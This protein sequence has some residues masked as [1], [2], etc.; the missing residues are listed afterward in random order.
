MTLAASSRRPGMAALALAVAGA[1]AF[2]SPAALADGEPPAEVIYYGQHRAPGVAVTAVGFD[3]GRESTNEKAPGGSGSPVNGS[4]PAV[5]APVAISAHNCIPRVD[6]R[7]V[8][9]SFE[10]FESGVG[11]CVSF[12]S[13]T[14]ADHGPLRRPGRNPR[15]S[16]EALARRAYE[17]AIQL[18]PQPDLATAPRR[19]GLTGLTSYFWVDN[20]PR[21]ISATAGVRGLTVTAQARPVQYRWDFGDGPHRTT[22]HPGRPW[23]KEKR[24]NVGH[25]YE[26]K[27]RYDPT[28]T[29]IWAAQWRINNGPW[30]DL[31][32]FSTGD[33]IEYPVR[34]VRSLLVQG[35]RD[36]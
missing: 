30:R 29:V 25:L 28:V 1:I 3:A 14:P 2:P 22:R 33:T 34:E 26:T 32:Y 6:G 20:P 9:L 31:G 23:T 10:F 24:G 19:V 36:R 16:P 4:T 5:P 8:D 27:G 21:P 35:P 13:P 18:A 7:G 15:P 11:D 17:R 12:V